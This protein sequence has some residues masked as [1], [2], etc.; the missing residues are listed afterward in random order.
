MSI[1]AELYY[2]IVHGLMGGAGGN[3]GLGSHPAI[4]LIASQRFAIHDPL[5]SGL[6]PD[7]SGALRA[8]SGRNFCSLR[9]F[10]NVNF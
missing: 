4:E 7:E 10:G 1:A 3:V 9:K 8:N 2:I 6:C 5:A